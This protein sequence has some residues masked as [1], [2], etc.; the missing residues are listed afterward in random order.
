VRARSMGRSLDDL[1][2]VM[3]DRLRSGQ[4]YDSAAWS[5]LVVQE[6]GAEG[7]M[8]YQAML[9]GELLELPSN[10]F[11]PCFT[12]EA[13]TYHSSSSV[14]MRLCWRRCRAL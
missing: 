14:S 10:A 6:L 9:A 7:R 2:F 3:L 5:A 12:H 11:G 8:Q 1:T 4:S 13:T